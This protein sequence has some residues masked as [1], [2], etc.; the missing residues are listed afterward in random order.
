MSY[1]EP[2]TDED[3]G[4]DEED[5]VDDEIQSPATEAGPS[6]PAA[7]EDSFVQGMCDVVDIRFDNQK[8]VELQWHMED[9]LDSEADDPTDDDWDG[10]R[11]VDDDYAW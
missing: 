7:E 6:C 4:E 11:D 1:A 2:D 3:L 9:F 10:D 5:D 8:P